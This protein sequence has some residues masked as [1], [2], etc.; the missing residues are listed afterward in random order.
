MVNITLSLPDE[1]KKR[2]D[3]HE[4]IKWSR[5]V[6]NIIESKLDDFERLEELLSKS[7]LTEQNV[8]D[9]TKKV[10]EDTRKHVR[11]LMK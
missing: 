7:Q 8:A 5:V 11:E 6:R 10:D 1:L 3:E 4:E 9:L 2:M